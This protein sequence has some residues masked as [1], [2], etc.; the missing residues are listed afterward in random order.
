MRKNSKEEETLR[1][2]TLELVIWEARNT[3]KVYVKK[4]VIF[5]TTNV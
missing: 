1:Y 2:M 3:R 5:K 4:K